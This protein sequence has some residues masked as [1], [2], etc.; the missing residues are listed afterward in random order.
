MLWQDLVVPQEVKQVLV[1]DAEV[2]LLVPLLAVHYE[3][4]EEYLI[5]VIEVL[6]NADPYPLLG[7]LLVLAQT[8]LLGVLCLQNAP[9]LLE[10]KAAE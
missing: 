3:V 10:G 4:V 1:G 8:Q 5:E 9:Q 7:G 2:L 6:F